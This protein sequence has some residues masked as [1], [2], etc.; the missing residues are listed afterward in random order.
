MLNPTGAARETLSATLW[1][2]AAKAGTWSFWSVTLI[3]TCAVLFSALTIPPSVAYT[4][5][6][7]VEG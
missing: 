1:V 3:V 2:E 4:E 5:M 7:L 6:G